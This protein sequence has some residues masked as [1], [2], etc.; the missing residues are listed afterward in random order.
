V[1]T[2]KLD[3]DENIS[4]AVVGFQLHFHT[5]AKAELIGVWGH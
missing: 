3:G 1:D 5:L 2:P 4:A